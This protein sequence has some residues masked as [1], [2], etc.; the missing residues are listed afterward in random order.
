MMMKQV[1]EREL[2]FVASLDVLFLS[3]F[4]LSQLANN[5]LVH[6]MVTAECLS[7]S[8]PMAHSKRKFAQCIRSNGIFPV[9]LV[10]LPPSWEDG[11]SN[12]KHTSWYTRNL[13][14]RFISETIRTFSTSSAR[15][16]KRQRT[17][18]RVT[19]CEYYWFTT[20][21][22]TQHAS[23]QPCLA[24]NIIAHWRKM[25]LTAKT[26]SGPNLS[27]TNNDFVSVFGGDKVKIILAENFLQKILPYILYREKKLHAEMPDPKF[28]PR[29][30]F[31]RANF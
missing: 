18:K 6:S 15:R 30:S 26:Q 19:C 1:D 20:N 24:C 4:S 31:I 12:A 7:L 9:H 14:R 23:P 16:E 28:Y 22:N 11:K 2:S 21:N 27:G 8:W 17:R 25:H 5:K 13:G 10:E 3:R 29:L